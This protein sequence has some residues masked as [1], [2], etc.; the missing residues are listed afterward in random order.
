LHAPWPLALLVALALL[1]VLDAGFR[2]L[3]HP[4]PSRLPEQFSP[5][6]LDA[7]V[8]GAR[9]ERPVIVLGDS[10][11]WG[12]H[13]DANA[14]AVA[15][16][17]RLEPHRAFLNLS[18]EGGSI[19]NSVFALRLALA[20][21]VV[22]SAVIVNLNSK[23]FNPADSA[24]SRLQPSLETDVAPLLGPRDRGRLTLLPP[25]TLADRI[26]AA[27]SRVWAVYRERVD[28]RVAIFGFDDAAGF[29]TDV[30][31]RLTGESARADRLHQPTAEAFAGTYDLEPPAPDNVESAYLRELRDDLVRRHVPTIAF[32]TPTNHALLHD[33]IDDPAYTDNL[34]RIATAMRGP[35]IRVVD[36]D[37][38]AVGPH[39]IDNDH[40]D[41]TGSRILAARLARELDALTP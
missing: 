29:V 23:E 14:A 10:T 3:W 5:A 9:N 6:Y 31:H 12:Y 18:Y 30:L 21:G 1:A 19:V 37:R 27:V 38:L 8:D 11:L 4:H 15:Q 13:L 35:S 36:L 39:F 7:Y 24:Y 25:P 22:P 41:A 40:L 17:A 34:R 32:L 33:T 2:I 16:L 20:H 26:D 28:I